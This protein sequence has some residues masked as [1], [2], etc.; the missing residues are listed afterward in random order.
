MEIILIPYWIANQLE[1]ERLPLDTIFNTEKMLELFTPNDLA[2][3]ISANTDA[4][5]RSAIIFG[6]M[7]TP[8]EK[9]SGIWREEKLVK[10]MKV[11]NT[12]DSIIDVGGG[13][14]DDVGRLNNVS[15]YD[16]TLSDVAN[17]KG[18]T[19]Y[20][21]E[22]LK[23]KTMTLGVVGCIINPGYF[24]EG[25]PEL[26]RLQFSIIKDYLKAVALYTNYMAAARTELFGLYLK[27]LSVQ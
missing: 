6:E 11:Y 16:R 25:N 8:T 1:T 27:H 17:Y 13:G 23:T 24:Y 12:T 18:T 7:M 14:G 22:Y 5:H 10:M 2:G 15:Y 19:P 21:F 20:K 9:Q 26:P 3:L 4:S